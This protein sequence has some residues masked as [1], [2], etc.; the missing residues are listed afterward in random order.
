MPIHLP[1]NVGIT[2][3]IVVKVIQLI[4]IEGTY[5]LISKLKNLPINE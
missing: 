2:L 4:L 3:I 5:I 1:I